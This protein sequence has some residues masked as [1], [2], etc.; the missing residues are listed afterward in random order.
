VANTFKNPEVYASQALG[1]LQR[2]IVLPRLFSRFTETD[3]RGAKDYTVNVKVPASVAARTRT[4]ATDLAQTITTDELTEA[5]VPV[6]L[7]KEIYSAVPVTD[8]DLTLQIQNFGEQVQLPQMRGIAEEIENMY[9]VALR[10]A[11]WS[12]S[13]YSFD[14][15]DDAWQ[16]LVELRRQLNVLNVPQAGRSLIVGYN[17]EAF[18]LEHSTFHKADES[19]NTSALAEATLGRKA[20]FT[21]V[22][23]GAIDPDFAYAVHSTAI[24]GALAAPIVPEGASAGGAMAYDGLAAT[25][26]RDYDA[27]TLR[28]RSIIHTFAGVKSV[29][30]TG[31]TKNFRGVPAIFGGS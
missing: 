28:D 19:G 24:C 6:V 1:L 7:T 25:W 10:D 12:A 29:E 15:T 2:E 4:L 8:L 22:T 11:D 30:E 5:V 27:T 17:V 16:V 31:D 13:D 3:F 20:G 14:G 23:S 21:I 18:L 26:L 9:A